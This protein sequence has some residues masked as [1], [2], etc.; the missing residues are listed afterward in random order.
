[1]IVKKL[2]SVIIASIMIISVLPLS[3]FAENEDLPVAPPPPAQ[4]MTNYPG[5][6]Q[7]DPEPIPY[8]DE[9][10]NF[11]KQQKKEEEQAKEPE[12]PEEPVIP[13]DIWDGA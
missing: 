3:V 1:M 4:D 7:R 13:D 8:T 5:E 9:Y 2:L 6:I 10:K 12:E 11:L